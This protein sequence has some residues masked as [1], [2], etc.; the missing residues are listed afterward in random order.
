MNIIICEIDHQ[1]RFDSWVKVL[2]A[3]ALRWPWGMGWEG[4]WEGG[5]GWGEHMY[6]HG[7]FM[8]I[9]SKNHHNIVISFQLKFL[10][11]SRIF[12]SVSS[13][14]QNTWLKIGKSPTKLLFLFLMNRGRKGGLRPSRT[15]SLFLNGWKKQKNN[16][17]GHVKII[18]NLNFSVYKW[19]LNGT[20]PH[21]LIYILFMA[22]GRDEEL[23]QRLDRPQSIKHLAI[24]PL[25]E[26]YH[27]TLK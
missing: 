24:C 2:R 22:D 13:T 25:T 26:K 5:S 14:E 9:Y 6:I 4:R 19:K 16:T 8:W 21:S 17:L 20:Q 7:W 1:S 3:G 12:C 15:V 18:W 11:I 27:Q 10:K 23:W